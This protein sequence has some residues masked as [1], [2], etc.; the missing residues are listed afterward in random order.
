MKEM[1]KQIC[2]DASLVGASYLV[3][4]KGKI[5]EK[6]NCGYSDIDSKKRVTN[7]TVFR[8]ASVSK[9]LVALC[10][11]RLYEE[12]KLD[13][14]AD[15]SEYLGF[16]VRNPKFPNDIIN[17]KMIMTQTSSITDGLEYAE[18]DEKD[19]G[20]N[21]INGTNI[22]CTLQDLL[23]PNGKYFVKETFSSYAPGSHFQ[24]SNLGCGI[25]AC[26]VEKVSGEYF[27]EYI[28]KIIFEPLKL[29]ASFVVTDIKS[30]DVASTYIMRNGELKKLRDREKFEQGVYKIFPLGENFRGPAGG[31]FISTNGLMKIMK[32]LL[33]GGAPIIKEDTLSKMMQMTWAG[34]T[35]P[36]ESYSAKGL[37]LMICD[38]FDNRRLYGH[39]GDAY[40][41]KSHFLFN[42]KEQF[43]MI[44][45][46]NGGGYKYQEC[47]YSDVQEKLIK[48]TL[49]KYWNPE[50][51]STFRFNINDKEGYLL[52]RKIELKTRVSK[53]V[54]YFSKLSIFDAFG[55]STLDDY[56]YVNKA[57]RI[58]SLDEIL[59]HLKDKYQ[60][61]IL[62]GED[63]YMVSYKH[64]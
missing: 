10:I 57:S 59:D 35:G 56:D 27:T 3:F 34:K 20:Y 55:I 12:G 29:D 45:I 7:D 15:I 36:Y 19:S 21:S 44:F 40:G 52:D 33:K 1:F 9:I 53:G 25:L 28:K 31:C 2:S 38:Y 42:K 54:V 17:L 58:A 6:I 41:V 64:H 18:G 61:D 14:N 13:L 30:K 24:Y 46:T 4:N 60:F 63:S 16:K 11:M 8:I 51:A 22:D 62:K 32:T 39:F 43:G 5:V 48:E 26:V 37:Q 49:D 50:I 47:G 23:D